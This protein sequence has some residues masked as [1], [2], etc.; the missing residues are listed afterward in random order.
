[1]EGEVLAYSR[2]ATFWMWRYPASGL[3]GSPVTSVLVD[4]GD[5]DPV[6]VATQDGRLISLDLFGE[7]QW[8]HAASAGLESRP[9]WDGRT[10]RVFAV[11]ANGTPYVLSASGAEAFPVDP[12]TSLG[13]GVSSSLA[14]GEYL[15]GSGSGARLVRVYYYGGDD[16][17]VYVIRT[18]R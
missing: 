2:C 1:M 10:G 4:P 6:Y 18:D 11:D 13:V 15:T 16:G 7:E 17:V 3:I 14:F 5:I 8:T 12:A 9:V